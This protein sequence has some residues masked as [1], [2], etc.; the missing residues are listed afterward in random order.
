MP[1]LGTL[2]GPARR[3]LQWLRQRG[4]PPL[5][6][7]WAKLGGRT[8][9][10]ARVAYV[11]NLRSMG[12]NGM[13]LLPSVTVLAREGSGRLLMVRESDTGVWERSAGVA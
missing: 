10:H 11:S 6:C 3:R 1:L 9:R 4:W 13:L 8:L 5:G 2:L 12:G 7:G